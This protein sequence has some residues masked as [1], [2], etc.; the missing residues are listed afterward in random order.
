MTRAV[1]TVFLF[2]AP[3]T[4]ALC[5]PSASLTAQ[6][7][8]SISGV[9]HDETTGEPLQY[10]VVGCTELRS[11]ALTDA[12]GAFT[13]DSVQP[14]MFRIIT[15]RRG[16]YLANQPVRFT[17]PMQLVIDLTPEDDDMPEGP[18]DIVGVVRDQQT[19]QPID[20]VQV[21]VVPTDQTTRTDNA[22]RFAIAGVSTGAIGLEFKRIGYEP[23]LDTLAAYPNVTVELDITLSAQPIELEPMIVVMRNPFLEASGFYRRAKAR[24]GSQFTRAEIERRSPVDLGRFLQGRIPSVRVRRGRFGAVLVSTR[25]RDCPLDVWVDGVRLLGFD[26]NTYPPSEVEAI[27][28]YT[29]TNTSVEYFSNC[30]VVLLWTRRGA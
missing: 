14:G 2:I 17:G 10:A 9:V 8:F 7:A 15:H 16:Y 29:G 25:G 6:E 3:L 23:R 18:G 20:G 22:G 4:I 12:N 26:I 28:V 30:G 13:L 1:G 11:W 19:G 27:E 5:W 24:R 21:R